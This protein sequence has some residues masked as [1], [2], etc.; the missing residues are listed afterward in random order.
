MRHEPK[1]AKGR[2]AGSKIAAVAVA[3]SLAFGNAALAQAMSPADY[4]AARK[5]I[6]SDFR[7]ATI[8][9]EPMRAT[10]RVVCMADVG[11]RERVALAELEAAYQP[12]PAAREEVRV[13]RAQVVL[14]VAKAKCGDR[15]D[16]S[17]DG[18]VKDAE[19]AHASALADARAR[20]GTVQAGAAKPR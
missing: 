3:V 8:G 2:I 20:A 12:S 13:A 10:A 14:S 5:D 19:D 15:A 6:V 1:R 18:C 17:R 7:T 9:C 4:A 16:E 11:G